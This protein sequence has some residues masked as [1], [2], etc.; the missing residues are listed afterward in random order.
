MWNCSMP[1]KCNLCLYHHTIY[2]FKKK[3]DHFMAHHGKH[4]TSWKTFK[5]YFQYILYSLGPP[6]L[7]EEPTESAF[8]SEAVF[9]QYALNHNIWEINRRQ[10]LFCFAASQQVFL[11]SCTIKLFP[12]NNESETSLV[13]YLDC[14]G[15]QVLRKDTLLCLCPQGNGC[16][17]RLK[18]F[19]QQK[20]FFK[21]AFSST[22]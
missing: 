6:T 3:D 12:Q 21:G 4:S 7:S 18:L 5:K 10:N 16:G 8:I 19:N 22:I 15:P 1:H 17:W 9:I 14:S 11:P 20:E 13:T 2:P